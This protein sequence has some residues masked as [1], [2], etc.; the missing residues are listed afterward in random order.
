MKEW[1]AKHSGGERL[2]LDKSR[3]TFFHF[4]IKECREYGYRSSYIDGIGVQK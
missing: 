3:D 2:A 4:N 1:D